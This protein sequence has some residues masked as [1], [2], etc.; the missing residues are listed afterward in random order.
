MERERES[1]WIQSISN[2]I[3]ILDEVDADQNV[4]TD[5][6]AEAH[7]CFRSINAGN[8]S[9]SDFYIWRNEFTER[10]EANNEVNSLTE[11]IWRQFELN[12]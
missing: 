5:R 10:I 8:G 11:S 1:N 12:V 7:H 3:A 9:F 4:A 2:I 6:I